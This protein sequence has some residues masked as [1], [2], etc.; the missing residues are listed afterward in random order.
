MMRPKPKNRI[1]LF[2]QKVQFRPLELHK[3]TNVALPRR[4]FMA[5]L[6][7]HR[8]PHGLKVATDILGIIY[9][10]ETA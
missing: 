2:R 4:V 9:D 8:Q 6:T 7:D 5:S 10:E 3:S 1:A